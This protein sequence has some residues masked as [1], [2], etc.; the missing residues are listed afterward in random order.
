M[1]SMWYNIDSHGISVKYFCSKLNNY[2]SKAKVA[3]N[4]D[5]DLAETFWIYYYVM[6]FFLKHACWALH[7]NMQL[8]TLLQ[9][10]LPSPTE[11]NTLVCLVR[12]TNKFWLRILSIVDIRSMILISHLVETF[13]RFDFT[14][15]SRMIFYRI[16]ENFQLKVQPFYWSWRKNNFTHQAWGLISAIR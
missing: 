9:F 2:V 4:L 10:Y 12:N 1:L 16:F 3:L 15:K 11:C 14:G 7:E 5:Y 8:T 13:M 6:V